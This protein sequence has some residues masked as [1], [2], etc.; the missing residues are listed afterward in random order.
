MSTVPSSWLKTAERYTADPKKAY[1]Y[2][3]ELLKRH[4]EP[5]SLLQYLNE[6]R[7][8]L[9]LMIL[10]QSQCLRKFLFRHPTE[11]EKTIPNLWYLTKDKET[12]MSELS[13][14]VSGSLDDAKFSEKLAFYR[15]RELMRVFAKELLRVSSYEDIL[16]E[17]SY[18][19]DALVQSAFD[20]AWEQS[21]ELFGKPEEEDGKPASATVIALGKLG[22]EELNYYSDIDLIFIHSS[23][24]GR[25]GKLTLN[26]FFSRFFQKLVK[27]MTTQ[28]P[29]GVPY[30]V[31]LD[32]R[33]FGKSG[34][35]SMSLRSAELYY[36]SYGRIW[37][38]F[39]L[40]RSR[41]SAG[42]EELAGRFIDEV[43]NPFVF[44]S[45]DYSVIEE[46]R[47]MKKRIEAESK[48]KL[49]KGFNVKTGEGGIREVEFSV[50]ALVILLGSRSPLLRERN[51][52]R[53]IYKLMQKGVF[54]ED[55]ARALEDAYTFLRKLEHRIQLKDCIRTQVLKEKDKPLI[56]RFL[57]FESVEEFDKVLSEHRKTVKSV[58]EQLLPR[59]EGE[60]LEDIQKAV[61]A[62]DQ[63]W[64]EEILKQKGFK[65]PRQVFI[66][67]SEPI[68]GS[69]ATSLSE[70]DKKAYLKLIPKLIELSLRSKTPDEAIKNF[71]K[72]FTNPTGRRVILSPDTKEDFLSRLFTVFSLS[73]YLSLLVSRNPDLVEDAL[74]LYRDFPTKED[75][76]REF[77][78]YKETL[79][80]PPENLYRRFKTVWEVRIGL[81]YF[82]KEE[83]RYEK[84]KKLFLSLSELADF[85]L[86]KLWEEISLKENDALL[87]ALGKLGSRE[88]SFG[89]DL[90]L[91]FCVRDE[92]QKQE[93]TEKAKK[94]V[95]FLTAHT[96]E[97]YLYSVD[98]RLR[99]MG[100]KGELV[101]VYEFYKKYFA[102]E[103]RT[104]ERLAWTRSRP[105]TGNEKL[106]NEFEALVRDFLFS[107]PW[108]E[109]ERKEVYEMRM[110]LQ[111]TAKRGP[112]ILDIKL[113]AGG[114][115]DGEFLV[116]Y[117]LIKERIRESSM[118]RGF[119]ILSEKYPKLREAYESFMFL[120]LVETNLR[121]IKE[122]GTS[123]LTKEDLPKLASS[124]GMSEEEFERE[125]KERMKKLREVFNEF[126]A[127]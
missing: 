84:L 80:L 107:K 60:E 115:V 106:I 64:G 118:I 37:E 87:Y 4:P 27:L 49:I 5:S 56:A 41:Y 22:S 36:E 126:L 67:L 3:E 69:L 8:I 57:G 58:F 35:I 6:R 82:L 90:D 85:I 98:F 61:L 44:S 111:S 47:L 121:L 78:R 81:I 34:P 24:K 39:A 116:Q 65:N 120:R 99:P 94:L 108:G 127:Q 53:A 40:L 109:K 50:Q 83:D 62:E 114:I 28:T 54:S 92:A 63:E 46:I 19:A 23:D 43:V 124:L 68:Y 110:K 16:S 105:V 88:L 97:G 13:G 113:G 7:F 89:S 17:Y 96:S 10:E 51:T 79:N 122:R 12:Y 59:E 38:R 93:V 66:L 102:K 2:F 21:V 14:L 20:R 30:I 117:L 77:K 31:D 75:Y 112:G 55:E 32:L 25:A 48:K 123:V 95:R 125:L 100:T 33:P 71:F 15:H 72:F 119:E 101:P 52:Y 86:T 18:L 70:R 104:W 73:R 26:E 103:A 74:T 29:E 11:F 9:L 91:V 45:V 76:E 42:D 1:T